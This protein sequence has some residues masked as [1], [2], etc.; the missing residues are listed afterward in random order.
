MKK[1]VLSILFAIISVYCISQEK[2]KFLLQ[3]DGTYLTE[4]GENFVIVPFENKNAHDIYQIIKANIVSVYNN[5]A[6][7]TNSVEDKIIKI[8]AFSDDISRYM[9]LGMSNPVKGHYNI[10]IEI[11]DE[12][13]KLHAPLIE[14]EVVALNQNSS[15]S[16]IF[17]SNYKNGVK[18][19][20]AKKGLKEVQEKMNYILNEILNTTKQS[21]D[22]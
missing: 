20:K 5:A 19:D 9:A 8:R 1:T 12:R 13:I 3:D 7:V 17:K 15:Y 18:K 10:E 16:G 11:K 6:R 2:V 22:W 14:E 4:N 21:E